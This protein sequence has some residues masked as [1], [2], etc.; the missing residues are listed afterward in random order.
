[1]LKSSTITVVLFTSSAIYLYHILQKNIVQVLNEDATQMERWDPSDIISQP[2][3]IQHLQSHV[4]ETV[5]LVIGVNFISSLASSSISQKGNQK[6]KWISVLHFVLNYI[7]MMGFLF[8]LVLF[9]ILLL[10][11]G[12][13]SFGDLLSDSSGGSVKATTHQLQLTIM[14]SLNLTF[15][16]F[17]YFHPPPLTSIFSRGDNGNIPHFNGTQLS[18]V[19]TLILIH[20]LIGTNNVLM[21]NENDGDNNDSNGNSEGCINNDVSNEEKNNLE[22]AKNNNQNEYIRNISGS[23]NMN[24]N[25]NDKEI[26]NRYI[27]YSTTIITIP[28]QILNILDHGNQIQ[29][30]PIPIIL[31]STIGH[32]IGCIIAACSNSTSRATSWYKYE[33]YVPQVEKKI[34]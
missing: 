9:S 15:M 10:G 26:I 24:N 17:G 34:R 6:G 1:M 16:A 8:I 5:L 13:N 21:N 32:C 23:D 18:Q 22:E 7:I 4:F 29:R 12:G 14:A 3:P 31:G 20:V 27:M 25:E 33:Q 28:F 11:G 19:P 2:F 30:W